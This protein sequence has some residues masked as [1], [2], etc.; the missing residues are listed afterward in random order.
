MYEGHD[1]TKQTEVK[2]PVDQLADIVDLLASDNSELTK[3]A[4]HFEL[5]REAQQAILGEMSAMNIR[6]KAIALRVDTYAAVADDEKPEPEQEKPEPDGS[7]AMVHGIRL[8]DGL[9]MCGAQGTK[10]QPF[11]SGIEVI[12]STA[13][14]EI[15]CP[16]C[17]EI[18]AGIP[19]V[20]EKS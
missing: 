20:E 16:E 15:T 18:I 13:F 19:V 4:G 12:L 9:A 14:P 3:M 8:P 5:M 10:S 2:L 6:L 11:A 17:Q 7:M 1:E